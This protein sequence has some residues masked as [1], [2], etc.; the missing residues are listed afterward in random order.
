MILCDI[1]SIRKEYDKGGV[2]VCLSNPEGKSPYLASQPHE[3]N[4]DV[5]FGYG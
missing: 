3:T 4:K 1:I 5:V 2:R